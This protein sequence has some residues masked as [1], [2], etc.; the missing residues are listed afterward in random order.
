M[1]GK[2]LIK[3]LINE[4]RGTDEHKKQNKKTT[5]SFKGKRIW[6]FFKVYIKKKIFLNKCW[7]HE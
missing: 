1:G 2:K 6:W 3:C 5:H 4:K 7:M